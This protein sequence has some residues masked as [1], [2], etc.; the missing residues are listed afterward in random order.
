VV[1]AAA[2]SDVDTGGITAGPQNYTQVGEGPS[3][4]TYVSKADRKAPGGL[5]A[6]GEPFASDLA[7]EYEYPKE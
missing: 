1:P 5:T 4:F 3:R 7:K 2:L 6:L